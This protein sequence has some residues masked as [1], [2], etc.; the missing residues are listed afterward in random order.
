MSAKPTARTSYDQIRS[1]QLVDFL[2]IPTERTFE[3]SELWKDKP[4]IIVVIRRPGCQF[5]REEATALSSHRD[6]IESTMGMRMVCIVREKLG[7]DLFQSEAWKRQVY[8]DPEGAF[9]KALGGHNKLRVARWETLI[10]PS[11]WKHFVRNKRSGIGGNFV[12]DGSVLG[13]L[14][15]VDNKNNG[16]IFYEYEEKVW[17]DI[18]PVEEVL[19]A[20]SQ[21]TGVPVS[22]EDIKKAQDQSKAHKDKVESGATC[23]LVPPQETK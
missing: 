21:L 12:G 9:Y 6:I 4:V 19:Q 18:A 20:A 3:A 8:F 15:I 11:F 23:D 16:S 5:C 1:I 13:G 22:P 10:K 2:D 14:L 7:A 17:G